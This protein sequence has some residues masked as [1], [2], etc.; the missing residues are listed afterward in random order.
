MA[1]NTKMSTQG[2]RFIKLRGNIQ[3]W[4]AGS[5][6]QDAET[7][8]LGFETTSSM[9]YVYDGTNWIGGAALTTSTSTT[10]T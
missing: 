2:T 8:E 6:P 7:G 4:A 5:S 3:T 9:L 1:S 10:T